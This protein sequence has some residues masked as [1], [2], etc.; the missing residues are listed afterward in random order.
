M[1][2]VSRK[3]LLAALALA[4]I[5]MTA[6]MT[7]AQSGSVAQPP[8][9]S[10]SNEGVATYIIRLSNPSLAAY[11]GGIDGLAPTS[12]RAT[13]AAKLNVNTPESQAYLNFLAQKRSEFLQQASELIGR[14]LHADRVF[15]VVYNGLTLQL[16]AEEAAQIAS[17]PMVR[18]IHQDSMRYPLTDHG[19]EWIG[20][21]SIWGPRNSPDCTVDG[22]AC[23]EGIVIGVIDTGINDGHPSFAD[24][25][26]DG[27]DH[28]NP[29]GAGNYKGQCNPSDLNYDNSLQC[30]DKL[31]GM[32]D[33]VD[34]GN[35]PRDEE[36]HGSHTASTAAGNFVNDA[37][38]NAPTITFTTSI[39]GVAPHAN[40]IAYRACGPDG[41]PLSALTEA[42][43]QAVADEVDVINYSIGGP[44]SNP[45]TDDDAQAFLDAWDANI[46]VSVS[47]GNSGPGAATLGSPADAPWVLGVG[48]ATHNRAFLNSLVDMTTDQGST[49]PDIEGR[50]ITDG[51]GPAPIVYAGD[52]GNALCLAGVWPNDEFSGQIVVC[53]RGQIARVDKSAN[54]AAAGGGGMILANSAAEGDGIIADTHS[55]P[56][57]HITYK[58][59]VKLKNWLANG[60]TGHIATIT[61][62]SMAV[63]DRFG[64]HMAS[65]SS[66]GPDPAAP[67]I[68]K[69]DIIGPGVDIIAAV[70]DDGDA[71]NGPD[72][73]AYSGTSMSSPHL[74][75]SGILMKQA[76]PNWTPDQIKSAIMTTSKDTGLV[77]AD[78]ATP[79]TP[80][81]SGAGRV[82]LENAKDAAMLLTETRA[83]YDNTNPDSGGDPTTLNIASFGNDACYG[84][85]SWTRTV[86][87]PTGQALTW[88][89]TFTGRNGLTGSLSPASLNIA[90]GG[91]ASFSL[92]VDVTGLQMDE[93]YFGEV[94]W[95]EQSG[96]APDAHF[97]VA[98]KVA[99][100]TND[101]MITK[102]VDRTGAANGDT[103]NYSVTI[104]NYET[105]DKA[106][107]LSDPVPGGASF[108]SAS[109]DWTYDGSSNT[110]S[111][112]GTMPAASYVAEGQN[113]SGFQSIKDTGIAIYEAGDGEN[114]CYLVPVDFYYVNKHYGDMILS[115]NGVV[116]AGVGPLQACP[117]TANQSFPTNDL[118]DDWDN[119]IA[120]FWTDL[121]PEAGGQIYYESGVIYN[122]KPH[123]V[124]EWNA[125][126]LKDHNDTTVTVQM[127]IEKGAD[128]VWFSYPAGGPLNGPT[129]PN[130]TIGGEDE[131]GTLGANYYYNG[132]GTIPDGSVD[133]WVGLKPS[134]KT[135]GYQATVSGG[136][137]SNILNEATV[138]VDSTVNKAMALT[139]VCDNNVTPANTGIAFAGYNKYT[140]FDWSQDGDIYAS[141][142]LWRSESPYF[143]PGDA[144]STMIWEGHDFSTIDYDSD[145]AIKDPNINYYYQLRTLNCTGTASADDPSQE[146][147]FD[148]SLV[149][150]SN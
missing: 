122:G 103:L 147:E 108:V 109:G 4:V 34:D 99:G 117:P 16:S 76:H 59:G 102:T 133:V 53:D 42:I 100:S 110:L 57:V 142:Q 62:T 98:V 127:W 5:L 128:N 71:S 93:W 37:T 29:L 90:A 70:A 58:D 112:N 77:E 86:T 85:C 50:S 143:T 91:S 119:L 14:E 26:A 89:G 144:S 46:F 38:L 45:W 83:N 79:T 47:A 9:P 113:L 20:A 68:V 44:S 65:F 52:Y 106:F 118:I 56:S 10:F 6:S 104:K 36:G 7:H 55:I 39:S 136:A 13:G 15:D 66:R 126:P 8:F 73:D 72:Y 64:D 69:P 105:S 18:T 94:T 121:D 25:G 32:Y 129:T 148:F 75:G 2:D 125:I 146:G 132:T 115:A 1:K 35:G 33:F 81:S 87:N 107:S 134:T 11:R 48:A 101:R 137:G 12:P 21:P 130:A 97:P 3:V 123:Y 78:G 88:N 43:N 140:Q 51:Y 23:G 60:D 92:S 27:Y 139:H 41:C 17:L 111:W 96:L 135:F 131:T 84:N 95:T 114:V 30:N 67:G 61:G 120:P 124:M 145:I 24:V 22:G 82:A 63:E 149:P 74:A 150:G 80:F 116:R 31:I 54:V 19:P 49:L 40:I 141:Y 138:T 28:T